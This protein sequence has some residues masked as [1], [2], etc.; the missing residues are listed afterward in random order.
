MNG[1]DSLPESPSPTS[2]APIDI[3]REIDAEA[4]SDSTPF[5]VGG[6]VVAALVIAAAAAMLLAARRIDKRG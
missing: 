3:D 5:V 4:S 6:I 2:D 1:P